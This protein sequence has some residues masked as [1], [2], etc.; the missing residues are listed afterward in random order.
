MCNDQNLGPDDFQAQRG[1]KSMSEHMHQ[2]C[3]AGV[4]SSEVVRDVLR[5]VCLD[6]IIKSHK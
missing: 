6:Q 3:G 5:A 4:P 1:V 2:L